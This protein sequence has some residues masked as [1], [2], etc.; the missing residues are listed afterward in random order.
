MST[1]HRPLVNKNDYQDKFWGVCN[2]TGQNKLGKLLEKIRLCNEQGKLQEVWLSDHFELE[3]VDKISISVTVK[4]DGIVISD[5]CQTEERKNVI[6]VGKSDDNDIV[7]GHPTT[8]RFHALLV[9][10]R[11]QGLVLVDLRAA[12]GTRVNG[13]VIK[14]LTPVTLEN[15]TSVV[16]FGVILVV[17][18]YFLFLI[19]Q[20]HVYCLL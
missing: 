16:Q 3:D 18:V 2:G 12:N 9:V 1:E 17:V 8:S 7:L 19:C 6:E 5:Y 15:N 13:N 20:Y 14:P 10:D 4:K 11:L